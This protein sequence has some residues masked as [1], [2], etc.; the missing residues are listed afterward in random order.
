MAIMSWQQAAMSEHLNNVGAEVFCMAALD[1]HH[2]SHAR[3]QLARQLM[4]TTSGQLCV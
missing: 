4:L 3:L 2:S 1:T